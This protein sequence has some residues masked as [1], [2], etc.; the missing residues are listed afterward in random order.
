MLPETAKLQVWDTWSVLVIAGPL[1]E[2]ARRRWTCCAPA[3][4][5]WGCPPA[6]SPGWV[7]LAELPAPAAPCSADAKCFS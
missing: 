4:V 1:V 6:E 5:P 7:S 2:P 3:C